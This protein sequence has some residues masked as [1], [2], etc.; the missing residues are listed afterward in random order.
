MNLHSTKKQL[1]LLIRDLEFYCVDYPSR[2]S[3]IEYL[4]WLA[5]K[6]IR[7][8][9]LSRDFRLNVLVRLSHAKILVVSR[10]ADSLIFYL[11]GSWIPPGSRLN[12]RIRFCHAR[13]VII[14]NRVEMTGEFAYI[15]NNVTIGKLI[16]G[17]KKYPDDMPRFEGSTVFGVGSVVV[18]RLTAK[19][20]VVFS[21]NCFCSQLDRQRDVTVTGHNIERDGVYFTKEEY[22]HVNF[23]FIA[24][25]WAQLR[26]PIP[27]ALGNKAT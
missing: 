18:G 22:R 5:N 4:A 19:H 1:N 21:A 23:P 7:G 9:F 27:E 25:R 12:C 24:P 26:V 16:P 13:S 6:F 2:E 11:Y 15:F 20:N 17:S 14:G 3:R 10:I 8:L